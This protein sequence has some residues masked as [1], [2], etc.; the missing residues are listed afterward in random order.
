MIWGSNLRGCGH[1]DFHFYK[2]SPASIKI[3]GISTSCGCTKAVMEKKELNAYEAAEIKV[4]L[5]QRVIK[6]ILIWEI[7]SELYYIET[8]NPISAPD[9]HYH[10]Q[11]D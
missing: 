3:T 8:D 10:R 1:H 2:F 7:P 9:Q 4:S 6:M 5:I 11:G